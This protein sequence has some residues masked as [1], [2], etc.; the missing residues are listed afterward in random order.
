MSK[1]LISRFSALAAVLALSMCLPPA[2]SAQ[3]SLTGVRSVGASSLIDSVFVTNGTAG[4][5]LNYAGDGA[6]HAF[7]WHAYGF[8][9]GLEQIAKQS[10]TSASVAL[11]D[12]ASAGYLLTIDGR[13]SL[14]VYVLDYSR[15]ALELDSVYAPEETHDCIGINVYCRISAAPLAYCRNGGDS[16]FLPRDFYLI[17]EEL[18]FN[19]DRFDAEVVTDTLTAEVRS[20]GDF[21]LETTLEAPLD[22]TIYALTGD[23]YAAALGLSD[24]IY[25]EPVI[26]KAVEMHVLAS[27]RTRENATNEDNRGTPTSAQEDSTALSGSAP[28]NVEFLNYSSPAAYYYEWCVSQFRDFSRCSINYSLKDF[29]Y[30]FNDFDTYYVRI[31]TYNAEPS[32]DASVNCMQEKTFTVDVRSSNLEIPS[33]FTPNGDGINDEFRVKYTSLVS[34]HGW[35]YNVWGRKVYEWTDPATGWDGTISGKPAAAGVY[36][37]VIEAEGGDYD[38]DGKRKSYRQRGAVNLLR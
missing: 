33:A 30:T 26:A 21:E 31:R 29:R 1:P 37:Y 2:A 12:E 35:I 23:S 15:T 27:V 22:E 13:D 8:G 4:G 10:G 24:T 3:F 25:S 19:R 32:D 6:E 14:R 36:I 20:A 16:L 38:D 11:R 7:S 34:F 9:T 17:Y 5:T 28:L 18:T